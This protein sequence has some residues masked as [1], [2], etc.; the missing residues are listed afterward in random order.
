MQVMASSYSRH[1]A[2]AGLTRSRLLAVLRASAGPLGVR[3]VAETVGLHPKSVREQL[4][5]LV[6]AGLVSRTAAHPTGRGRPGF[7]Y[8]AV[9]DDSGS[10]GD[11]YLVLAGVL[12][13]QLA[14][15]PDPVAGATAA[16]E[17]WGRASVMD[18]TPLPTPQPGATVDR[19]VT[20]LEDAGFAPERPVDPASPTDPIRLRRCPFGSLVREHQAI[21]CNIHL[22]LMRGALRALEAPQDVVRLEPFVTP[23]VCVVHLGALQDRPDG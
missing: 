12:A 7:R 22:G 19:L 17:R 18:S 10:G 11:A 16:G 8:V 20:L 3:E 14:R 21:V 2:L 23:D 9:P 6:E 1:R 5:L 4:D 15:Q 13:G